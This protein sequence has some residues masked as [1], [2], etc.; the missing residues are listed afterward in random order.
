MGASPPPNSAGSTVLYP[1][2][3]L[4]LRAG[5]LGG[6]GFLGGGRCDDMLLSSSMTSTI[7]SVT[8]SSSSTM[9]SSSDGVR[10]RCGAGGSDGRRGGT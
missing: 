4:S 1:L 5:D 9:T 10:D 2:L 3:L 7:S 8:L 6:D